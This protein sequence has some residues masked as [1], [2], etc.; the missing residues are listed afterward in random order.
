MECSL[1]SEEEDRR[2]EEEEEAM[3]A[4]VAMDEDV[5]VKGEAQ[6]EKGAQRKELRRQEVRREAMQD[7]Q[8]ECRAALIAIDLDMSQ[9]HRNAQPETA[10]W[11]LERR[12]PEETASERVA[13]DKDPQQSTAEIGH[14]LGESLACLL[15]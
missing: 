15:W 10:Q 3:D 11:T 1:H 4:E 12:T 2:Q 8:T 5:D 9:E 6:V 14:S 7:R 13:S